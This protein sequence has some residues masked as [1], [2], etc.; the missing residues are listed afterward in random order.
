MF[1]LLLNTT[2]LQN[3]SWNFAPWSNKTLITLTWCF[4]EFHKLFL[5]DKPGLSTSRWSPSA[6]WW[7]R[8]SSPPGSDGRQ[9]NGHWC[10][11]WSHQAIHYLWRKPHD[12]A[13]A[14]S[15]SS[16]ANPERLRGVFQFLNVF[17]AMHCHFPGWRHTNI[18]Q[19]LQ[20]NCQGT[21]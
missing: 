21:Y 11:P 10:G 19:S 14:M 4:I 8:W 18:N 20:W 1:L 6:A 5:F 9:G 13:I 17:N 3:F 2:A 15:K 7:S 16:R 12:T